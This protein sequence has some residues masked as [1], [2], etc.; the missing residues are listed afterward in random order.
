M[1]VALPRHREATDHYV[2]ARHHRLAD[3]TGVE[4]PRVQGFGIR[5]A[6]RR[7]DRGRFR[8]AVAIF[9]RDAGGREERSTIA[10]TPLHPRTNHGARISRQ[11]GPRVVVHVGLRLGMAAAQQRHA[12]TL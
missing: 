7:Q 8:A 6:R 11:I 12:P 4:A 9:E 1:I 10:A 2:A 5:H 3:R